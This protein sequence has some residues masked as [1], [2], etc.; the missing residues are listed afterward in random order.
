MRKNW[1]FTTV[2]HT[3]EQYIISWNYF[4]VQITTSIV[5]KREIEIYRYFFSST[6]TEKEIKMPKRIQKTPY[7]EK[8]QI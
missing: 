7:I 8:K 4:F 3:A 2:T 6:I 1:L 5:P